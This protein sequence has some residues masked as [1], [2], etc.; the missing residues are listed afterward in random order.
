MVVTNLANAKKETLGN[1]VIADITPAEPITTRGRGKKNQFLLQDTT[2]KI[3]TDASGLSC[4]TS[5]ICTSSIESIENSLLQNENVLV[6]KDRILNSQASISSTTEVTSWG[7]AQVL[8]DMAFWDAADPP[9]DEI[10]VCIVGSGY[11]LTHPDLPSE[12]DVIGSNSSWT[13]EVWSV[14][15][16]GPG[17][18]SA[19]TIAAIGSNDKGVSKIILSRFSWL[20]ITPDANT[21]ARYHP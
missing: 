8:E 11:D 3:F 4:L 12:P 15:V 18:H 21:G 14:D 9:S 13:D 6:E 1:L 20:T 19:G 7:V 2:S 16:Y 5:T 17:T 10:K